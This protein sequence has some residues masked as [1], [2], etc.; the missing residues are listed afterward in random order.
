[1]KHRVF[2]KQLGRNHNERQALLR[3][4]VTSVFTHGQIETT[5]AKVQAVV[6]LVEKLC[7]VIITK[8]DLIARR[9]VFK[10]LQDRNKTNLVV[11]TLKESF[12]NQTSNFTKWTPVKR[13]QGDDA[14]IV[15]Y[16]FVKE[17]KFLKPEVKE[18]KKVKAPAK[19][20]TV[21]KTIKKETK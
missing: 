14:L 21:K 10:Y 18:D 12:A 19:K 6:P 11:N 16:G 5:S 15:R 13:R 20:A 4:L 17:I 8:N 9:E 3:S 7:N 1:M 2:G